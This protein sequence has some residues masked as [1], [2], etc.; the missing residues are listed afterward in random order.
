MSRK[1]HYEDL[2][3]EM[4]S[5]N[6]KLTSKVTQSAGLFENITKLSIDTK[7]LN[8][9]LYDIVENCVQIGGD[10]VQRRAKE[11]KLPAFKPLVDES[12]AMSLKTPNPKGEY[13]EDEYG[14]VRSMSFADEEEEAK[15]GLRQP[16]VNP[17]LSAGSDMIEEDANLSRSFFTFKENAIFEHTDLGS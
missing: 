9:K 4:E 11:P 13:G 12:M 16:V 2:I 15:D 1:K 3:K 8:E 6:L 10:S 7:G 14:A 17:E 5:L